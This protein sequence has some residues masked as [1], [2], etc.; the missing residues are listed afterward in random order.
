MT[1]SGKS[2]THLSSYLQHRSH[3][4]RL[5]STQ[6]LWQIPSDFWKTEDNVGWEKANKLLGNTF[7]YLLYVT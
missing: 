6:L 4:L 1:Q 7:F 2:E 3:V 5:I